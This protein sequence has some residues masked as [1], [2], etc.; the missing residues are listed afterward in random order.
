MSGLDG[1]LELSNGTSSLTV[2]AEGSFVFPDSV[3][4]GGSFSIQIATQPSA[5]M[6]RIADAV[7]QVVGGDVLS[8]RVTCLQRRWAAPQLL[9]AGTAPVKALE[10]GLDDQGRAVVLYALSGG[11]Q[12]TLW[13]VHGM[14]GLSDSIMPP[15]WST[16]LQIDGTVAPF[17]LPSAF[18]G[19][20]LSLAVSPNG[21]AHAVWITA[22][23]CTAADFNPYSHNTCKHIFSARYLA[24]QQSW[25]GP[26]YVA[27]TPS[28]A[29]SVG[30]FIGQSLRAHINDRGDT[31]VMYSGWTVPTSSQGVRQAVAWR[32]N[33]AAGFSTRLFEDLKLADTD[34][35]YSLALTGT[36]DMIVVGMLRADSNH[37]WDIVAYHGDVSAGFESNRRSLEALSGDATFQ[38]LDTT[39]HGRVVAI[40]SQ[41]LGVAN[42]R[43]FAS[44]VSGSAGSWSSPQQ[45]GSGTY[46][47]STDLR[48]KATLDGGAS[49]YV[50]CNRFHWTPL[51]TD[52]GTAQPVPTPCPWTVAG[53]TGVA[54]DGSVLHWRSGSGQWSS[55]D[56]SSLRWRHAR[57]DAPQSGDYMLGVEPD[58]QG[59]DFFG[60]LTSGGGTL[61]AQ[62]SYAANGVGLYVAARD[63][64]VAPSA[65]LPSGVGAAGVPQLW[66]VYLR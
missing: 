45:V 52:W 40:W 43:L 14:P 7:G 49:L 35:P 2:T 27:N 5:Q 54:P 53:D 21:N 4:N 18:A 58:R 66:G 31:A 26:Y 6:C 59:Q 63:Y 39:R 32:R 13:A 36:G 15:V 30:G 16:P 28:G 10:S 41:S 8:I 61:Y 48:L 34:T 62:T 56:G 17:N 50:G 1:T 60:S 38:A 44:T 24:A 23:P 29:S 42:T 11:S 33:D 12:P 55:F 37:P 65:S 19:R 20:H 25:D 47:G 46:G 3:A 22:R 51:S 57:T 9:Q 64:S